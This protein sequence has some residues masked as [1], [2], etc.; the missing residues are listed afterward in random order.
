[1]NDESPGRIAIIG[2]GPVGLEAAL[3][4]RFLGYDVNVYEA[5]AVAHQLTVPDALEMPTFSECTSPLG[6]AAIIA[7]NDSEPPE[8]TTQ[9][10]PAEWLAV[11][12]HPLATSDLLRGRIHMPCRVVGVSRQ[13]MDDSSN[14]EPDPS[15]VETNLSD[16]E[17]TDDAPPSPGFQFQLDIEQDGETRKEFAEIVI[18]A[19][20]NAG[21]EL[22]LDGIELTWDATQCPVGVPPWEVESAT[23]DDEIVLPT[24]GFFIV[25]RKRYGDRSGFTLPGGQHQIAQ[26]FR[27]LGDRANL[28]LYAQFRAQQS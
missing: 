25:G 7:Q 21:T 2:A 16:D 9:P 27:H 26:L 3:Y 13:P 20:G 12:G 4:G 24:F 19:S 8:L 14:L 11:Y 18:D 28:D 17:R 5:L 15:V 1:M 10:T 23:L 6:W 22:R